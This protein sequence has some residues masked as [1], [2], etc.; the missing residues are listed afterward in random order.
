MT[1]S[2]GWLALLLCLA[3]CPQPL[4]PTPPG[5]TPVV[6]AGPVDQF[7]NGVY[8]C[9]ALIVASQRASAAEPVGVCLANGSACLVDLLVSFDAATVAC[10]ARDLGASANAAVLSGVAS[11]TDIATARNARAWIVDH[12]LGY[13]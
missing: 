11:N 4:P 3:G 13:K 7:S 10:V 9:R 8:D 12:H 6:D 5:P 1:R 2:L